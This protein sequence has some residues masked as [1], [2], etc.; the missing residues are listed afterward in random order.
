MTNLESIFGIVNYLV[1][2][3]DSE[4]YDLVLKILRGERVKLSCWPFCG[5]DLGWGDHALC[6]IDCN[7]F[8]LLAVKIYIVNLYNYGTYI[9]TA[10]RE[11]A[12]YALS[13]NSMFLEVPF[14][15]IYQNYALKFEDIVKALEDLERFIENLSK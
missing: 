11:N 4:Y 6:N 2:K 7:I 5:A 3:K 1:S 14:E 9:F 10:S 12:E 13:L 15:H 8:S